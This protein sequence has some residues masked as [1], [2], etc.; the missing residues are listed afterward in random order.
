MRLRGKLLAITLST[1]GVA[2]LLAGAAFVV[3]ELFRLR[4]ELLADLR[5]T[6]SIVADQST[7]ALAFHDPQAATENLRALRAKQHIVVG[8][9][10]DRQG[11]L[12]AHYHR[13][14]GRGASCAP[15]AEA[16]AEEVGERAAELWAPVVLEGTRT[17]TL[18]L[19]GDLR[20]IADRLR[21]QLLTLL[22]ALGAA[23]LAAV[24]LSFW[25]QRIIARPIGQLAGV[26]AEVSA[27][28]TY[29]IR[30]RRQTEDEVGELVD[31]F[32]SMLAEVEGRDQALRQ[33]KEDLERA[34][35]HLRGEVEERQRAEEQKAELLQREQEARR[36]A[37]AANRL[38]DEFLATL[39]H[40][41]RTPLNAIV[42]W[43]AL[44]KAGK[45]DEA[46]L[47]RAVDVIERNAHAQAQLVADLLD[48]SVVVTGKVQLEVEDTELA[49]M[50][51]AVVDSLR[52]AADAR[53]IRVETELPPSLPRFRADPARLQ[54]VIWNLLSN[55]VKF[56]QDGGRVVLRARQVGEH[57]LEVEVEDEGIGIRG[58]FLPHVFERFRQQDSSTTRVHGGLGLGLAIV[59]HLVELHG[60][61]VE[62]ESPGPGRGALFRLRLPLVP[63]AAWASKG[64]GASHP[65]RL[66]GVSILLVEDEADSCELYRLAL[67]DQGAAVRTAGT[68]AEALAI[69][70]DGWAP[71]LLVSDVGLPG[72]DGYQLLAEI[73]RLPPEA[74]G[75]MP[76]VALTAYASE[77]HVSRAHAAGFARHLAKPVEPEQLVAAVREILG[78][79]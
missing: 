25:L 15:V 59:R 75:A 37:E 53:H 55:A 52:P 3:S 27:R 45:R 67:A 57:A 22:A 58:D 33:A 66:D 31:A 6:A 48:V 1:T 71:D 34:N 78:R 18:Y 20:W 13:A 68:A 21:L 8:C 74:G 36:E 17:G 14:T 46:T 77:D 63:A 79:V 65:G 49:P 11:A 72:R 40:E 4:R 23:S 19:R 61:T 7:A 62:A 73:R 56:S 50:V 5:T 24:A 44:L 54:Q 41:L 70:G 12:F 10:Y 30:A 42:G 51:A 29:G 35:V 39:S 43:V 69:L 32:N 2:L 38:K 9:L 76:A 26:A 47:D 16:E 28:G 64:A 60:G